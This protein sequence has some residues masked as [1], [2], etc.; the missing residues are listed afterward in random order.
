MF[1]LKHWIALTLTVC[2][3]CQEDDIGCYNI[4][5]KG[6]DYRGS[7][8]TT[9]ENTPCFSWKNGRY[10]EVGD[11]NQA[12]TQADGIEN[13]DS[14]ECR[15]PDPDNHDEPWCYL[16]GS[17][18]RKNCGIPKCAESEETEDNGEDKSG[19]YES[20]SSLFREVSIFLIAL[21][22]FISI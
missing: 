3:L 1:R 6:A 16:L 9:E 18:I 17:G 4:A 19:D 11:Y 13:Q 14:T 7:K 5:T 15:N 20:N 10:N 2:V 22:F 8:S 12:F 21:T